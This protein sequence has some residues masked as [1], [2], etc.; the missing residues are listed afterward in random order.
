VKADIKKGGGIRNLVNLL[1]TAKGKMLL[2]VLSI[3]AELT[4]VGENH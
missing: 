3:L 1:G 2:Q 4:S